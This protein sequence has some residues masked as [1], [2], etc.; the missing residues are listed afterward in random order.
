MAI[1]TAAAILGAGA[2]AGGASF[3]TGRAAADAQ[4]DAA[5]N[6]TAVQQAQL[7]QNE[8][9]FNTSLELQR[10]GREVGNQ[11]LNSLAVLFGLNPAVPA[12]VSPDQ[13]ITAAQNREIAAT[14]GAP[15]SQVAQQRQQAARAA[16]PPQA[17]ANTRTRDGRAVFLDEARGVFADEQGNV[18][19][20]LRDGTVPD[21]INGNNNPVVV[22]DGQ[23]IGQGSS[24]FNLLA[25]LGQSPAAGTVPAGSGLERVPGGPANPG[26]G[27]VNGNILA[28]TGPA[29]QSGAA[30][31]LPTT[32]AEAG[33]NDPANDAPP[34][35]E[36]VTN[37]LRDFPVADFL[38][39]EGVRDIESSAAARGSLSSGRTLRALVEF[40]Q[41]FANASAVQPFIGG[42]QNL[43][44]VGAG[45]NNASQNA[46]NT[47]T[48]ANGATS[49]N[50]ANL[51]LASGNARAS[52]FANLNS[53][54]QGT[55]DNLTTALLLSRGGL[56]GGAGLA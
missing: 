24:G 20:Q 27:D 4:Q 56:G 46:V 26:I 12:G 41:N 55:T 17:L 35:Q 21:L 15:V 23:V 43:A 1:S 38:R 19:G 10:P 54:V 16:I 51:A 7:E 53:A 8:D 32:L 40:N 52:E 14:T 34:T 42:L 39:E 18:V 25:T 2:I 49:S 36:S 37:A 30:N 9:F 48:A 22:S 5:R 50:L 3:L 33:F 47:A 6:A 13:A 45:A 31:P 11:A 28:P 44:G 29:A